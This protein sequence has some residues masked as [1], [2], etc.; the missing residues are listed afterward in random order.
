MLVILSS[1]HLSN[2]KS[3]FGNVWVVFGLL[4]LLFGERGVEGGGGLF[5]FF[6]QL[7]LLVHQSIV[8]RL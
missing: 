3:V 7:Q 4:L 2:I 6:L 8:C 5:W 1:V